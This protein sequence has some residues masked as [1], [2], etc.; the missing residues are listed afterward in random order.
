MIFVFC[1]LL[2]I[3]GSKLLNLTV[4]ISFV[5]NYYF[6]DSLLFPALSPKSID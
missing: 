5:D 6:S 3:F 1:F 2:I 4:S